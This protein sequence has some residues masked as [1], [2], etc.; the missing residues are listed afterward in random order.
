MQL[1]G[2][3]LGVEPASSGL[4]DKFSIT[5]LQK[6]TTVKLLGEQMARALLKA[7]IEFKVNKL[8]I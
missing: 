6:P 3:P 7:N 2:P 5:E 4:L 1:Q 8:K